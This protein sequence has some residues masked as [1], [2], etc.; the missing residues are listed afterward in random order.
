MVASVVKEESLGIEE[1]MD[2]LDE[3]R[4][5]LEYSRELE[6]T[7]LELQAANERLKELDKLK[8]EF[9][10]TVT[11]E[12]RT[13]L[14]SV[15]ALAEILHDNPNIDETQKK[16]FTQIIIKE[17]D[18]LTRLISK[19]LDLQKIESGKIDWQL[20][21]IDVKELIDDALACV[22]QLLR[23]KE[24]KSQVNVPQEV[25]RTIG[26]RDRLIQV[27]VNLISNAV[28]FCEPRHGLITINLWK[29][30]NYLQVDV[31]DNGIGISKEDQK[32][33]FEK[34]R[35][36]KDTSRGRPTGS[37]LGLTITKRI[38]DFHNGEVWVESEPGKGS[39]FS[40]TLPIIKNGEGFPE[41]D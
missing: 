27:L 20:T 28:K 13:P 33:I 40:F 26:D 12:L 23:D 8:D 37:G 17:T 15:R 29:K 36:V 2:I 9:I 3:T 11:H 1:V 6:K 5:V 19:V 31:I 10:S 39:V 34:F 38:I 41:K 35:Q 7:S 25:P 14:T 30:N 22:S 24:I 32:I 16:Q 21:T 4:Q 18:R